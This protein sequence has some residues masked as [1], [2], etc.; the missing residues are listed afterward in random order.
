MSDATRE[1]YGA[2]LEKQAAQ[3]MPLVPSSLIA[4]SLSYNVPVSAARIRQDLS[5]LHTHM[6]RD[7]LGRRFYKQLPHRRSRF[8]A[9]I[10][11]M[12]SSGGVLYP[13]HRHVHAG[14]KMPPL[15]TI[16]DFRTVMDKDEHGEYQR[17][18]L[19]LRFARHGTYDAQEFRFHSESD[20]GW[21]FYSTKH[22]TEPDNIIDS[23]D[24]LRR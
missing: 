18:G 5:R 3:W 14:W 8:W 16:D 17:G 6:D 19:W 10:E 7:L 12:A 22:P 15:F 20:I 2:L 13:V 4:L 9:V 21:G 23:A 11:S 1:A 24:F